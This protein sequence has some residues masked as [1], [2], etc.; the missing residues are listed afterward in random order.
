[1]NVP[2]GNEVARHV[3]DGLG[4]LRA[5]NLARAEGYAKAARAL[6]P[7]D[8]DALHL[9]GVVLWRLGRAAEAAPLLQRAAA[10]APGSAEARKNLGIVLFDLHRIDE[11]IVCFREATRLQP[12]MAAVV[13][14]F[15]WP[16]K[17]CTTRRSTPVS[18]RR[19]A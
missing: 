7:D 5:G 13:E 10:A 15:V 2:T 18:K 3:A 16:R 6:A 14:M 9:H 8:P 4:Q 11:A 19:V 1:V 12:Q 17:I